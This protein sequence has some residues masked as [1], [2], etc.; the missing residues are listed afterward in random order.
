[1]HCNQFQG[2]PL[3]ATPPRTEH[4]AVSGPEP[5]DKMLPGVWPDT[6]QEPAADIAGVALPAPPPSTGVSAAARAA[7]AGSSSSSSGSYGGSASRVTLAQLIA[8]ICMQHW[9]H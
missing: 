9:K 6:L 1:M 7:A 3:I 8:H 4:C 5:A 2:S